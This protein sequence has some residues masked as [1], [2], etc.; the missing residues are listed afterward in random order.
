[1]P[2]LFLF[3]NNDGYGFIAPV[4]LQTTFGEIIST[5][6]GSGWICIAGGEGGTAGAGGATGFLLVEATGCPTTTDR[7][8][9]LKH[10]E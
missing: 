2:V 9:N 7:L 4:K 5:G 10:V 6:E 8:K 3:R 1:V